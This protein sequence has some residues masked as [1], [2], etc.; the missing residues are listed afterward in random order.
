MTASLLPSNGDLSLNLFQQHRSLL[1]GIAYR[2]LGSVAEAEDMVQETFLRWQTHDVSQ[3]TSAKAWL[4]ATV[5]RLSI[6]QLRSAR[7]KRET[8]VGVWLP[9]PLLNESNG[10]PPSADKEMALAD[11]LTTAFLVLLETLSP[12]ER[13]VYLL[14]EVFEYSY[15]EISG[16][17]DKSEENCRQM[18]HRARKRV[19]LR[20][21]R[22]SSDR[23][24][25]EK[26]TLR[27]LQACREGNTQQLVSL[28]T[29]DVVLYSDGGGKVI[30]VPRP[31][32]GNSKVARFLIG[33]GKLKSAA[34]RQYRL[35]ILNGCPGVLIYQN[36]ALIQTTALHVVDGCIQS[37]YIMRNPDKLK[38]L[39]KLAEV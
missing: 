31:I 7:R 24:S 10:P 12:V 17:V 19:D 29:E 37:L 22:F 20:Q 35:A 39:V 8:Y 15:A 5:T 30:A 38:H 23:T 3:I 28:L 1:F 14:H 9:E 18:F 21:T 25:G 13:A 11:S 16:M 36:G 34:E 33:V 32:L 6:D 27:F 26:L 2:M 4:S